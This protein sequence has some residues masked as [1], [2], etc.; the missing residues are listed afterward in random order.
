MLILSVY[1]IHRNR[2]SHVSTKEENGNICFYGNPAFDDAEHINLIASVKILT[3]TLTHTMAF[4]IILTCLTDSRSFN[5]VCVFLSNTSPWVTVERQRG[6]EKE[7]KK[8]GV[9]LPDPGPDG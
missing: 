1:I 3:H 9:W 7:K 6:S 4:C 2:L 5:P 8:K